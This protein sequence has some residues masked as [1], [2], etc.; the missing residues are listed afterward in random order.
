MNDFVEDPEGK[1]S[2]YNVLKSSPQE[3]TN[4]LTFV[5]EP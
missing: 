2:L 3:V 5:P 1:V 4:T